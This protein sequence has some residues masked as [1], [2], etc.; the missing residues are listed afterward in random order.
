MGDSSNIGRASRRL[1]I[2]FRIVFF[3]IPVINV[4]VWLFINV[5]PDEMQKNILPHYARLPLPAQA[6]LMGF[7]ASM[8]PAAIAMWGTWT[9]VR[10][11]R[12]YETGQ[13]FREANV[14]CF[15]DM[16]RVLMTW[17]VVR[18]ISEPLMSVALTLHYPPGHRLLVLGLDSVD[19]TAL[20]VGFALAVIAWVMD[21]GR[22][23]Q[24]QEDLTI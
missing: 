16:S 10:L 21:E 22:K 17:C 23:L 3:L 18:F 14:R 24:E 9:L 6:R 1:E 4:L 20:L 7:F 13:I 15:R 19:I 12:L 2:V 11:F 8:I 5:M